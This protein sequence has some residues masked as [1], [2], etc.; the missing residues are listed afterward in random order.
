MSLSF[1]PFL[2]YRSLLRYPIPTI[3]ACYKYVQALTSNL[4]LLY[5]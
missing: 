1:L 4:G 3:A 2:L 5:T